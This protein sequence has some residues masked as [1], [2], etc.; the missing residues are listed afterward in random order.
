MKSV[1]LIRH[2][3]SDWTNLVSDLDRPVRED[4]KEDATLIAKEIA[5]TGRL[6]QYIISSPANRTLQT[7]QLLSDQWRYPVK[8][9]ATEK[10][11]YECAASDILHLIKSVDDKYDYIAIVC[12][13]PAITNFTNRFSETHIANVPTTGAVHFTFDI[14]HWKDVNDNGKVD[15]LLRP[16]ELKAA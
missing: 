10:G 1:T 7:A 8:D 12:H 4:R 9:I 16:K 6:P 5:K 11:L 15:W 2:V 3:K 13:N 14:N